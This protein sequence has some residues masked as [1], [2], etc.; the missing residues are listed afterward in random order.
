[1]GG[2]FKDEEALPFAG[3]LL[4]KRKDFCGMIELIK[5]GSDLFEERIGI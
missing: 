1:L 2:F 3:F 5:K 4:L